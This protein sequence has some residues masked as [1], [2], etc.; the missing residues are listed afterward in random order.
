MVSRVER[1][2]CVIFAADVAGYSRL[3]RSDEEGTLAQLVSARQKMDQMVA[4]HH[5]R[6]VNSV[7][8]SVLA[9]FAS[10]ID[11]VQAAIEIQ[12]ELDTAA[13]TVEPDQRVLFRIGLQLGEVMVRSTDIYG[14]GVNVAARLQTLAEP[15]GIVVSG[16]IHEQLRDRLSIRFVDLGEQAV[17]N[18]DRP[19]PAFG[20]TPEAIAQA[21]RSATASSPPKHAPRIP[22]YAAA[23][24]GVLLLSA[25]V[26]WAIRA[27]EV[28]QQ[29]EAAGEQ[30]RTAQRQKG[31]LLPMSMAIAPLSAPPE[32]SVAAG[33]ALALR[34]DLGTGISAV[35][36]DV[37]VLALDSEGVP[38]PA[39]DTRSIARRAGARYL[40]E[41]DVRSSDSS[42]IVNLRLVDTENGVQAWAGQST[43]QGADQSAES[44]VAQRKLVGQLASSIWTAETKRALAL[45]PNQVTPTELV[46][47][48][49]A[50]FNR[51]PTIA[52]ASEARKQFDA[53][54]AVD[55]NH[56]MALKAQ[57]VL[58]YAYLD[59]DPNMALDQIAVEADGFAKRA[60]QLDPTS[61]EVWYLRADSLRY[62][63]RWNAAIEA[64]D[65]AI[66]RDPYEPFYYTVKA[67]LMILTGKPADGLV[68]TDRALALNP[69]N[70]SVHLLVQCYALLLLGQ[71][72][73]A[74][75][76]CERAS[77]LVDY[78][79]T[80]A[81]LVAAF[82]NQGD[83]ERAAAAVRAL[84]K[85]APGYTIA[86]AKR[87]S[88]VPEYLELAEKHWFSGLRKAGIPEK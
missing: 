59:L 28:R 82:A 87:Y 2:L 80:Q 81:Y 88:E 39:N 75:Q 15:G 10:V 46:L 84:E 62:L 26:W 78:W 5:G 49:Q 85:G 63:R 83:V 58:L 43:F 35:G 4:A 21:P 74:I 47:Q 60:L 67:Y 27:P 79:G 45:P 16:T 11:A 76:A 42:K 17:K 77:G 53:A 22:V 32:D 12:R 57:L 18:I 38:N 13:A 33:F 50:A 41:G 25:A 52:S 20:L 3:M 70:P 66:K 73:R 31:T 24:V 65:Q 71:P 9:E 64:S 44:S 48:G 19:V 23:A 34:R 55:P 86:R 69:D 29:A 54:L 56:V 14:D 37:T 68:L 30:G 1:R 7:G 6:I 51:A 8:D 36:Q 72:S 40:L 61:P